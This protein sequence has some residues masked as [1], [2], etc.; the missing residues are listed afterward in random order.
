M[1]DCQQPT[2]MIDYQQP[3]RFPKLSSAH[4]KDNQLKFDNVAV[5]IQCIPTIL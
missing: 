4:L 5:R 1:I 3:L 2:N